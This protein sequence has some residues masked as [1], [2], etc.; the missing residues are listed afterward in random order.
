MRVR[1]PRPANIF[2]IDPG[3][4]KSAY[5]LMNPLDCQI[6]Q[7]DLVENSEL[8]SKLKEASREDFTLVIEMIA[9]YGQTVGQ[10]VFDTC[11]WIGRY[12]QA[13]NGKTEL[14]K[15]IEVKMHMCHHPRAKDADIRRALIE[16]IGE[17]GTK[18][19][20]GPTYGIKKDIWAALGLAITYADKLHGRFNV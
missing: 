17:P 3:P 13:F 5:V 18:K 20:P 4:I 12:L 7:F 19:D 2:V 11:V 8:L 6:L 15:R 16:R 14:V 1:S 9:C 10:T